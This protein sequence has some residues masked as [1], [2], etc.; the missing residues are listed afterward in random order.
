[1]L[2]VRVEHPKARAGDRLA[3]AAVAAAIG[4]TGGRLRVAAPGDDD[5]ALVC[6]I[7]RPIAGEDAPSSSR[8]FPEP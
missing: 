7:A 8:P 6:E 5:D 4:A 2:E 3:F 1:V